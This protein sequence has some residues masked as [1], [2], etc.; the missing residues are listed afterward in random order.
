M[1]TKK[2][3]D[4]HQR[5]VAE[6]RDGYL[7]VAAVAG[8][9][10]TTALIGRIVHLIESGVPAKRILAVTF[11]RQAADEMNERLHAQAPHCGARVGTFHSVGFQILREEF[12]FREV[13]DGYYPVLIK[14]AIKSLRW[15]HGDPKYARMAISM[16]K[17]A[18]AEPGSKAAVET[19][20]LLRRVY[21]RQPHTEPSPLDEVYAAAE[22][23]RER[24]HW[25]TFDDMMYL[26]TKALREDEALRQRWASRWDY[27]LQDEA[28][29]QSHTQ[30]VMAEELSRDHGNLMIVGD[31]SQTI[32]GFRGADPARLGAFEERFRPTVLTLPVS[33]RCPRDVCAIASTTLQRMSDRLVDVVTPAKRDAGKITFEVY[34]T[35]K[36][37]AEEIVYRI[38]QSG[39][40]LH[41]HAILLRIGSHSLPFESACMDQQVPYHL[42]VGRTFFERPE[43]E[44]LLAYLRLALDVGTF[45]DLKASVQRP[46]RFVS[47]QLVKALHTHRPR[48]DEWWADAV[49]R[50]VKGHKVSSFI[51]S[52]LRQWARVVDDVT[53]R[54]TAG[55]APDTL[56]E[57][58]ITSTG[59]LA[60]LQGEGLG[61]DVEDVV[62]NVAA[63][64]EYAARFESAGE[65]LD[66]AARAV[67]NAERKVLAN[68]LTIITMHRAKGLE[69]P[70]V[71]VPFLDEGVLPHSKAVTEAQL[72]EETRLFYV[73]VTRAV[74]A[75]HLSCRRT[76][77][78][79]PALSSL[80]EE[81]L[82]EAFEFDVHSGYMGSR[83]VEGSV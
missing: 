43:V 14:K 80:V 74:E 65:L 22:E 33:Y 77:Q 8:S 26:S 15:S 82:G 32:Y 72:A 83:A 10:K 21:G 66:R 9:G 11:S 27:V 12:N 4:E 37:A 67:R 29:D 42:V 69:W 81:V 62:D 35:S 6:F 25:L 41:E 52:S 30:F 31:P 50:T 51:V 57:H 49:E 44:A 1:T 23:E 68:H 40:P 28:Q 60:W 48:G 19:F 56:L 63:L 17:G 64:K 45:S 7:L 79:D 16:A 2:Q 73:S 58:V 18:L 71:H 78:G 5:R 36:A 20:D 13:K 47:N 75:L 34:D 46:T 53:E 61:V 54:F 38:K 55:A 24:G 70:E 59:Y 76:R 39:R 3:L